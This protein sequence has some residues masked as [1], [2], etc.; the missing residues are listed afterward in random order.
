[1]FLASNNYFEFMEED[2]SQAVTAL[3]RYTGLF[4]PFSIYEMRGID[5]SRPF[6]AV[7]GKLTGIGYS[8]LVVMLLAELIRITVRVSGD[9]REVSNY[10]GAILRG[11][12]AAVF[13]FTYEF[14]M[15]QIV[16]IFP[17][18]GSSIMGENA[19]AIG[20]QIDAAL[21]TIQ[22]ES[23]SSFRIWTGNIFDLAASAILASILSF[24]AL[25]LMWILSLL[26]SYLFLFWFLIGPLAIPAWAF[27]PLN[28]VFMNW[29]WSTLAIG[30]WSVT[31][32]VMVCICA[33]AH[34]LEMGFAS[35]ASGDIIAATVYS[36]AA[37][38]MMVSSV[39]VSNRVF[40][41]V[42]LGIRKALK[43]AKRPGKL[44]P[45]QSSNS[46]HTR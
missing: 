30:F 22:L 12:F 13:L 25:L 45:S 43:N 1:M 21:A 27:T 37:I 31:C 29:F 19:N 16:S 18:I 42:E 33:R 6:I 11:V 20:S 10:P 38:L 15:F 44:A 41:G 7:L 39:W 34:F 36:L 14:V 4:N 17:A 40:G 3:G 5:G 2:L 9:S 28:H 24:F 46:T 26:Q 35:G 23:V 32:S 8:I